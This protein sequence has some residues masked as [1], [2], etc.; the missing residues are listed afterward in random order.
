MS[1]KDTLLRDD[2]VDGYF[3]SCD[4]SQKP[5]IA[6]SAIF[7]LWQSEMN[8]M[9]ISESCNEGKTP[10][11]DF[12]RPLGN[13]PT[14]FKS[15]RCDLVPRKEPQFDSSQINAIYLKGRNM[16]FCQRFGVGRRFPGRWR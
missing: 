4:V 16:W 6:L 7:S 13:F 10:G 3:P 2:D 15:D 8:S 11:F 9:P 5:K 1:K 14:T 12:L